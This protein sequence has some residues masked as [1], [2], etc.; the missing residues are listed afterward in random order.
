M[1]FKLLT[2]PIMAPVAGLQFILQQVR[3]IAEREL[4]DVDHIQQELL[5]LHL[6]YDEGEILEEEF[7]TQEAEILARLRAAREHLQGSGP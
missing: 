4:L 7:I 1:F 3:T 6:R 2:A 5:L